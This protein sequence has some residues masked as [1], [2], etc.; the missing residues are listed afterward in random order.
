[1]EEIVQVPTDLSCR[2]DHRFNVVGLAVRDLFW[3]ER[4]LH[5]PGH[6]KFLLD[7]NQPIPG[8]QGAL[9][10]LN[11]LEAFFDGRFEVVE[12]N[13]LCQKVERPAVHGRA[14]VFHVTIGGHDDRL[15]ILFA[16]GKLTQQGQ[17]VHHG[18]VDIGE[19]QVD[20]RVLLQHLQCLFAVVGKKKLQVPVA[21]AAAELLTYQ[22][23]KI[24]FVID[25]KHLS[26]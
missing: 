7:G 16:I 19:D 12:I 18:H 13:R 20:I 21:D 14:N 17:A 24:F 5:V 2:E 25:D 15:D 6:V 3:L 10:S 4:H 22:Q 9:Q 26:W 11:V 1:M 23:L 8:F